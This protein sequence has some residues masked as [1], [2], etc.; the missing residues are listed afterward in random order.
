MSNSPSLFSDAGGVSAR[1]G[2]KY[3]DHVAAKYLLQMI[4]NEDLIQVECETSDDIV[5]VWSIDNII[6]QEYVQVKTT[7]GDKK[8]IQTEVL[9]RKTKSTPSSLVEKSLLCDNRDPNARF[10]IVSQRDVA[11]K[12]YPLTLNQEQRI[13]SIATDIEELAASFYK[14]YKTTKSK[15]D[16]DLA[17]WIRNA[18]WVVDGKMDSLRA[19][20]ENLI[21]KLISKE[22]QTTTHESVKNLYNEI[23]GIADS[24][25]S[26]QRVNA[27]EKII[28]AEFIRNWWGEKLT[29]LRKE[30]RK[31]FKPYLVETPSFFAQL[32]HIKEDNIFRALTGY[33]AQ[34]N[35]EEWR[36]QDLAEYLGDLLPEIALKASEHSLESLNDRAK[37]RKAV[38]EVKRNQHVSM[39]EL[40]L[41]TMLHALIRHYFTSEPVPCKIFYLSSSKIKTFKNVHFIPPPINELWLG[42]TVGCFNANKSA[43]FDSVINELDTI[44]NSDF[45]KQEKEAILTLR[46]PQHCSLNKMDDILKP[47][48]PLDELIKVLC[49]PI[50]IAYDSETLGKG[51]FES[52]QSDL[53]NEIVTHYETLKPKLPKRLEKIKIHIFIVPVKCLETLIQQFSESIGV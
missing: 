29:L 25:A 18:I 22:G 16:N 8:W 23:L 40:L 20:N 1:R 12:L 48:T 50:L 10:Q 26:A 21:S 4:H 28:T 44:L 15:N 27:D 36:S 51:F 3:Q 9:K 30:N 6:C 19:L 24:A 43:I 37:Y 46:E 41:E 53:I 49:I 35:V 38:L 33:D 31:S 2:F 32:H 42:R 17:Y 11:K 5:L 34:Y 52:Y 47:N 45:L 7:E 13:G 39:Y 14:K